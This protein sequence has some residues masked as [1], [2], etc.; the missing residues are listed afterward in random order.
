MMW[1]AII[2]SICM[3]GGAVYLA[4]ASKAE[5]SPP[6]DSLAKFPRAIDGWSGREA[7]ALTPDVLVKGGDY[8][9]AAVVGREVVERAGGEVHIVPL[10]PGF[11]S[12]QIAERI[13]SA[14]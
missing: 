3:L 13:R 12:S 11:S 10:I 6:R 1:R 5:D 9:P 8:N 14:R 7:P 2:V 4:G